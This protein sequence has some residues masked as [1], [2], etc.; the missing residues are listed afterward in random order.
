MSTGFEKQAGTKGIVSLSEATQKVTFQ[1]KNK[2]FRNK[3]IDRALVFLKLKTE[4][5]KI[6]ILHSL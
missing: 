5:K 3:S 6:K 1:F 2:Y 4:T